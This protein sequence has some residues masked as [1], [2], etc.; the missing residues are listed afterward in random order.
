MLL[1]SILQCTLGNIFLPLSLHHITTLDYMYLWEHPAADNSF[2][3]G[4]WREI[5]LFSFYLVSIIIYDLV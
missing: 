1:M 4:V 2:T 5:A 3:W